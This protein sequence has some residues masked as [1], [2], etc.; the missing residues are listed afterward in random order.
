MIVLNL[1]CLHGHR[2]EGW[3]GSTD[4]FD[5]QV[6]SR[7]VICPACGEMRI[8]RLPSGPKVMRQASS[9]SPSVSDC[10]R[11]SSGLFASVVAAILANTED[12]ADRFAEEARSMHYGESEAR[13][14]RGVASQAETKE[15]LDE[16]IPVLPVPIP[17]KGSLH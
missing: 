8:T 9:A 17:V 2:F 12:V 15:L 7:L 4:D 1:Q 3:F 11:S 6:S 10:E 5:A 14:I 13:A 16:G